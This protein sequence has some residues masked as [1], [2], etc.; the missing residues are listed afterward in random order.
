MPH[1]RQYLKEL[2]RALSVLKSNGIL[3]RDVK[4]GNFL[5]NPQTQKGILI[6]Y[7]L[8]EIDKKYVERL[9]ERDKELGKRVIFI[10]ILFK[11][12]CT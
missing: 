6:D 2:L 8:S 3:H 11:A 10:F 1:I 9:S 4:P 12:K 5:Y 7:G